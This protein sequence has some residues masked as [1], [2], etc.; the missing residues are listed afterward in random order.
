MAVAYPN[1]SSFGAALCEAMG[2][3]H[4]IKLV[5]TFEVDSLPLVEA[6]MAADEKNL[7]PVLKRF[8][9]ESTPLESGGKPAP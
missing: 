5:L 8:I 6:T 4:V 3:R 2:L 9:L 7:A 1:N